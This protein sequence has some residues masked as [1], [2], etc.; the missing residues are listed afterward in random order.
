MKLNIFTILLLLTINTVWAQNYDVIT[1]E[2]NATTPSAKAYNNTSPV[3]LNGMNWTLPGVYLGTPDANDFKLG[4][5]SARIRRLNDATGPNGYLEMLEDYT[6]GFEYFGFHAAMYGSDVGG[7][8]AVFYSTNHGTTWIGLDTVDIVGNAVPHQYEYHLHIWGDVRFRIAKVDNSDARINID[9]IYCIEYGIP[10]HDLLFGFTSPLGR[11]HPSIPNELVLIFNQ[12]IEEGTGGALK[13]V[14]T[15]T[16]TTTTYNLQHPD[17]S[18]SEDSLVISNITLNP[19]QHYYV[20]FDSTLV[21]S[22]YHGHFSSGIYDSTQW[23]FNVTLPHFSTV[24]ESFDICD[25]WDLLGIFQQYSVE[26]DQRW[27]CETENNNTFIS[28]SGNVNNQALK[29]EDWLVSYLKFDFGGIAPTLKFKERKTGNGN[30]VIRKLRYTTNFHV[31][32]STTV[33]NDIRTLS[34]SF[35]NGD[36]QEFSMLLNNSTVLNQQV[37]LAISYQNALDNS[38]ATAWKWSIDDLRIFVDT[39]TSIHHINNVI[40]SFYVVYPT[41][42]DKIDFVLYSNESLLGT[43]I[44]LYDINGKKAVEQQMDFVRGQNAKSVS[45]LTLSPGMYVLTLQTPYGLRS[46]K[47]IVH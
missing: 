30:N 2:T 23:K 10:P 29:N 47:L 45:G 41:T 13:L 24:E 5:N 40:P 14:N 1:F 8:L 39:T 16:N 27:T 32:V 36:W 4:N 9:N 37:N 44:T 11:I 33:W 19:L 28:M 31:N 17:L 21:Q 43:K 6:Q 42:T 3:S 22:E 35:Q 12:H 46:K 15:T 34:D 38:A 18:I 25:Q 20:L 26:G 7:Q